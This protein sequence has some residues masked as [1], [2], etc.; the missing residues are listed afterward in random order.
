MRVGSDMV[1]GR[2]ASLLKV[3]IEAGIGCDMSSFEEKKLWRSIEV[4]DTVNVHQNPGI[5]PLVEVLHTKVTQVIILGDSQLQGVKD[6]LCEPEIRICEPILE[7]YS[8]RWF[9]ILIF[10]PEGRML[11][12]MLISHLEKTEHRDAL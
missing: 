4:N 12:E 6:H 9:I 2:C 7:L 10:L 3:A 11:Q 5:E 1:G 8:K